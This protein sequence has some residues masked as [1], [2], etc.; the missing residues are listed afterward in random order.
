[1]LLTS[2]VSLYTRNVI[3]TTTNLG[4]ILSNN[5][6]L[7]IACSNN[8]AIFNQLSFNYQNLNSSVNLN[9][10]QFYQTQKNSNELTSLHALYF[11][12]KK[13]N[14][15]RKLKRKNRLKHYV[16]SLRKRVLFFVVSNFVKIKKRKRYVFIDLIYY[17][18]FKFLFFIYLRRFMFSVHQKFFFLRIFLIKCK[19]KNFFFNFNTI[20]H[21]LYGF[22]IKKRHLIKYNRRAHKYFP[23]I[24]FR[25][26]KRTRKYRFFFLN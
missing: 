15:F 12:F 7:T 3:C 20:C 17:R 1:M 18:S 6:L 4:Q 26:R 2:T 24:R 25:H 19:N 10:Q 21:F 23:K 13:F 11:R 16:L 14:L 22:L 8:D 9:F 5:N